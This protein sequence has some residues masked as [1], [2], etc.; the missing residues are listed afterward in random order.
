[1]PDAVGIVVSPDRNEAVSDQNLAW[2]DAHWA[3]AEHMM[4]PTT[5]P[6]KAGDA[7][8]AAALASGELAARWQSLLDDQPLKVGDSFARDTSRTEAA[9]MAGFSIFWRIPE[10]E[11]LGLVA[12][13]LSE[14]PRD[15]TAKAVGSMVGMAVADATGHWFEFMPVC[16]EPGAR[17]VRFEV[18]RLTHISGCY[19]P[20]SRVTI[21]RGPEPKPG[22]A[23]AVDLQ[24]EHPPCFTGA[25]AFFTP[26]PPLPLP[27]LVCH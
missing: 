21:R 25:G 17:G 27:R 8:D 6:Y 2:F 26:P 15:P 22:E 24:R 9:S 18:D 1:M 13:I 16:D 12:R 5:L 20:G 23:Q 19:A 10:A 7:R 4:M 11:R 14:C 3:H